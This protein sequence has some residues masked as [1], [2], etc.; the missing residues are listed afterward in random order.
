M[1]WLGVVLGGFAAFLLWGTGHTVLISLAVLTSVGCFWSWG[2]CT[3]LQRKRQNSAP[4]T[5]VASTTSPIAKRIQV[6]NW[7][8]NVNLIFTLASVV[9]LLMAIFIR[10]L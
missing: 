3:T 5:Q 8:T 2:V 6:P 9:I 4:A 1:G 10:V 7:I